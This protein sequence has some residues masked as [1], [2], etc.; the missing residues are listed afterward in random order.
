MAASTEKRSGYV[1]ESGGGE[2]ID[3]P[4]VSIRVKAGAE[5]TG[6]V[7]T[8]I[9]DES[10]AM[11]VPWHVHDAD[12]AYYILEG[13]LLIRCG[14]DTFAAKAG[15]FVFL[16]GGVPHEQVVT[17]AKA[18]KLMLLCPGGIE[19]FFRGM[20]EAFA[21]DSLTPGRRQELAHAHGMEFLD[22]PPG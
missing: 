19:G 7:F 3:W 14:E 11:T 10:D 5:Q 16:P 17:S 13:E 4:G 21:S 2:A 12:E 6:G 18:R 15:D 1:V 22:A 9:E 8:L 20:A